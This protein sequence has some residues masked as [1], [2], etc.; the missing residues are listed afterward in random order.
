MKNL[1]R[2]LYFQV[3]D[4]IALG[5]LLGYFYPDAGAKMK[6]ANWTAELDVAKMNSELKE[7]SFA[8]SRRPEAAL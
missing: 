1:F 8:A 4:A 6:V 7:T 5:V 3:L 2:S